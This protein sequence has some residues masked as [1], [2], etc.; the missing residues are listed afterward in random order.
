MTRR[1]RDGAL[2]RALEVDVVLVR[3]AQQVVARP[4]LDGLDQVALR[5]F[6]VHFNPRRRPHDKDWMKRRRGEGG[7][8]TPCQA[9]DAAGGR[10]AP[11]GRH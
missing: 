11:L 2:A 3:E 6:P 5:V 7:G 10:A 4:A 8:R 1:A 9:R